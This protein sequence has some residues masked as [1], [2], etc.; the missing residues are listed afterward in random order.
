MNAIIILIIIVALGGGIWLAMQQ[1]R[2]G[3]TLNRAKFQAA[4][5]KIQNSLDKNH[6]ATYQFAILSADKLLDQALKDLGV[7]GEKTSE[8]LNAAKAKFSNVDAVWSA[9]K[10]RNQ[11]AHEPDAKIGLAAARRALAAYK[12]ALK[13]LG[14]I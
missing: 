1:P 10:L 11:V 5:L 14:A 9:H 12:K 4:W 3:K 7:A 6:P 13:D 2:G 8:R